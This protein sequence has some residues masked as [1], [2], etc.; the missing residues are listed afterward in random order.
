MVQQFFQSQLTSQPSQR[1]RNLSL[2]VA[3]GFGRGNPTARNIVRWEKE[4]VSSRTIPERKEREDFD[5]WMYDGDL[6]DAMRE[7]VR[8]QGNSKYCL[9]YI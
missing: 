6:N 8:T 4:W 1:R 7:F 9:T 3:R 5:S 2:N